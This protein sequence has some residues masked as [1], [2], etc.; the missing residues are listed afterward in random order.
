MSQLVADCACDLGE[1]PSWDEQS[2]K[3]L[4]VDIN[5]KSIYVWDGKDLGALN[6]Q[7]AS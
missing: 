5:G 4:S 1:S 7:D 2:N 6:A 3:L